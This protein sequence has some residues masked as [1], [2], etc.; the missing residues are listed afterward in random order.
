MSTVEKFLRVSLIMAAASCVSIAQIPSGSPYTM[1]QSVVAAGGGSSSFNAGG[2][3]FGIEGT[4]GQSAA[5]VLSINNPY[6]VHGGFWQNLLGPTA[7]SVSVSGRV[8]TS[9]GRPIPRVLVALADSNG[10]IRTSLSNLFGLFRFDGIE[11]GQT[12]IISAQSKR[13]TFAPRVISVGDEITDLDIVAL[14]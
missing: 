12:Y 14:P 7:A 2:V 8:V 9:D 11:A 1:P 13:F 4:I 5:G 6:G 10:N 3:I